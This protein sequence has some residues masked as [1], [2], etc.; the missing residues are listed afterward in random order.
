M[1][2]I[3]LA[4]SL[5]ASSSAYARD[6]AQLSTTEL[7]SAIVQESRKAAGADRKCVCPGDR[8]GSKRCTAR[9]IKGVKCMASD[10]TS[11]DVVVYCSK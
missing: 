7:N 2:T 11:N 10:V 5:L 1:R 4:F 8:V 9:T 6:C 3:I